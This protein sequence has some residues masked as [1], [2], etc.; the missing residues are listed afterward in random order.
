MVTLVACGGGGSSTA[1]SGSSTSAAPATTPTTAAATGPTTNLTL[2][3]ADVHLAASEESDSGMRI[4]LPAGVASATVTL[5]GLPSPN[6]VI[7]VCQA[8][9]L[10]QRMTGATCKQPT[11]GQAVTL[12][13]GSSATGVEVAQVGPIDTSPTG[14]SFTISQMTVTYA[15]SSRQVNVRLPSI[16]SGDAG[17]KPSFTLS[18]A[19]TGPYQAALTWKVIQVFGGTPS[20]GQLDLLQGGTSTSQAQGGGEVH[21]NGSLDAYNTA[22]A[23][24]RVS[25][26]G[27]SALVS[28]TLNATLP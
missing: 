26:T 20:S 28:P 16:A 13:L 6:P 18:P 15:A 3:V 23:S 27:G 8:N 12:T 21:L 14:N 11:S 2:K 10:D 19:G 4:L 1:T 5:A 24:I 25:N 9:N 22:E 7:Q 17:G